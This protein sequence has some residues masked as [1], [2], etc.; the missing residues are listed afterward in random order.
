M[1]RL[2]DIFP[3]NKL[4]NNWLMNLDCQG[5][6][7]EVLKGSQKILPYVKALVCEVNRAEVYKGCPMVGEIDE[8]LLKFQFAR[9]EIDWSQGITWSDAFYFKTII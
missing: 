6:E 3:S 1:F 8:F 7:L 9:L 4:N 2:D 5:F